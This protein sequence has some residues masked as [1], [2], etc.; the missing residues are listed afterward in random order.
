MQVGLY[1]LPKAHPIQ[2]LFE[3]NKAELNVGL[4][5]ESTSTQIISIFYIEFSLMKWKL[6]HSERL[7]KLKAEI[8]A[9]FPNT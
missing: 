8:E 5:F 1:Y 7:I 2:A 9:N 3:E 4:G 6:S